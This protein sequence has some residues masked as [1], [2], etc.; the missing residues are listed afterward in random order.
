MCIIYR[1]D[2]GLGGLD[3]LR[4]PDFSDDVDSSDVPDDSSDLAMGLGRQV[5]PTLRWVIFRI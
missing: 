3:H 4:P 2:M 1:N 5:F